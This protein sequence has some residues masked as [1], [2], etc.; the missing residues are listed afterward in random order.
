MSETR[1]GEPEIVCPFCE[2]AG[3][4]F[5]GLKSHLTHEDCEEYAQTVDA[6]RVFSTPVLPEGQ[7][8]EQGA[9]MIR[10]LRGDVA[11]LKRMVAGYDIDDALGRAVMGALKVAINDHGPIGHDMKP[12]A[13]KRIVGALKVLRNNTTE[14]ARAHFAQREGFCDLCHREYGV[15]TADNDLWNTVMRGGDRA[16]AGRHQ[17]VCPTCFVSEASAH[18]VD[19]VLF[20][21]TRPEP[22]REALEKIDPD[23]L[24]DWLENRTDVTCK[25]NGEVA[26]R[27]LRDMEIRLR[28]LTSTHTEKGENDG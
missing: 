14:V 24:S 3:F 21:A 25:D 7:E 17:F 28:A 18:G 1:E 11:A 27:L 12:S 26:R 13:V 5:V 15:W 20:L 6:V 23:W 9:V 8:G 22:V 10:N 4:D 19:E 2:E 16:A